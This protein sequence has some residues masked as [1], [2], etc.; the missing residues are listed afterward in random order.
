MQQ[1]CCDGVAVPGRPAGRCLTLLCTGIPFPNRDAG[2]TLTW[3][4]DHQ[5]IWLARK[6]AWCLTFEMCSGVGPRFHRPLQST[7]TGASGTR[8]RSHP[9]LF[10]LYWFC[11]GNDPWVVIFCRLLSMWELTSVMCTLALC[12]ALHVS[13]LLI[14]TA[15]KKRLSLPRFLYIDRR[16]CCRRFQGKNVSSKSSLGMLMS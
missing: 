11:Y 9:P 12:L 2:L 8:S 10:C 16:S 7:W 4:F 14:Y 1:P 3:G 15:S 5:T 6:A 13:N